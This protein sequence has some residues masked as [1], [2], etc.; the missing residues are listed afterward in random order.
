MT[1]YFNFLRREQREESALLYDRIEL[2]R[3]SAENFT[4][5]K[6][7]SDATEIRVWTNE[8]AQL[9]GETQ[10]GTTECNEESRVSFRE[11]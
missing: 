9:T 1:R 6:K 3:A 2:L 8:V 5:R 7:Y 10:K 4:I 11:I